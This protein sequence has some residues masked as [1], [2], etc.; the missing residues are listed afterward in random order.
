MAV[1]GMSRS[2]NTTQNATINGSI[3]DSGPAPTEDKLLLEDGAYLLLEDGGD[4][5]IKTTT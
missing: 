5:L 3:G 4:I 1:D 2:I